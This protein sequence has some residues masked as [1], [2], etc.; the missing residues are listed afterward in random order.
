[1][2]HGVPHDEC[3]TQYY[4]IGIDVTAIQC[5]THVSTQSLTCDR[6]V[7]IPVRPTTTMWLSARTSLSAC[8]ISN[9]AYMHGLLGASITTLPHFVC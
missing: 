2:H 7:S 5:V 9:V 1:M 3:T 6:V 8:P 4:T